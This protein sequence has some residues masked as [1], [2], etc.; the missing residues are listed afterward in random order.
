[1]TAYVSRLFPRPGPSAG[2]RTRP[3]SRY[4][5]EPE[6]Y[7]GHYPSDID[8]KPSDEELPADHMPTN[9]AYRRHAA[10][11]ADTPN[12]VS[13]PAPGQT[14]SAP[15]RPTA[16]PDRHDADQLSEP[17]NPHQPAPALGVEA[18]VR[19]DPT[20]G[21]PGSSASTSDTPATRVRRDNNR[22][23]DDAAIPLGLAAPPAATEEAGQNQS[24]HARHEGQQSDRQP[25]P[26]APESP[27]RSAPRPNSEP[28]PLLT[29]PETSPIQPINTPNAARHPPTPDP[30]RASRLPRPNAKSPDPGVRQKIADAIAEPVRVQSTEVVVNIDRID[31]RAPTSTPTTPPEPRRARAAPTSLESYLRS[32]SRRGGR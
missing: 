20:H 30:I 6:T 12:A 14:F 5:P 4:E 21:V 11:P 22:Q 27:N 17:D 7:L 18:A 3:R 32:R 25:T 31:V 23:T 26:A 24:V 1:M 19:T 8:L 9:H 16:P 10:E 13:K 2:I 28:Y 29:Q 15:A